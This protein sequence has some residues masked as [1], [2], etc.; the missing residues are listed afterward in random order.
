LAKTNKHDIFLFDYRHITVSLIPS[1]WYGV[2]RVIRRN[3]PSPT[4][5]ANVVDSIW[6]EGNNIM[7]ELWKNSINHVIGVENFYVAPNI[8]QLIFQDDGDDND[9]SDLID[10]EWCFLLAFISYV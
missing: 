10:S 9:E 2:H 7:P 3:N 4:L 8:H 1:N 6:K 5:S